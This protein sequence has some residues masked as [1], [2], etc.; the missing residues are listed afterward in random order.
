MLHKT[1]FK[2]P[3]Q[4]TQN[5]FSTFKYKSFAWKAR[6][7]IFNSCN[8][9]PESGSFSIYFTNNMKM[10]SDNERRCY[11]T[12]CILS[13]AQIILT[14]KKKTDPGFLPTKQYGVLTHWGRVAYICV[15]ELPI[16]GSNNGLS[17]GRRQAIIWTN[18]GILLIRTLGIHFT[19]NLKRNSYIFIQENVFENVVWKT[20]VILSRPQCDKI[21]SREV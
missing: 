12:Q 1:W 14:I 8:D 18:A 15:S 20:A 10:V 2:F 19:W 13:L 11:I 21:R 3:S 4:Q 17:P 7:T 6:H 16:I 9:D 5:K